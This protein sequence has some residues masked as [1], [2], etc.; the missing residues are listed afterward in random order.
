M[1][2]VLQIAT[3]TEIR[4]IVAI[5]TTAVQAIEV[6]FLYTLQD[7]VMYDVKNILFSLLLV[8]LIF[9]GY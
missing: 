7:N 2:R 1:L 3:F 4:P 9:I 8:P 5:G 6:S